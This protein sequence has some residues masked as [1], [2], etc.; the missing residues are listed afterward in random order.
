VLSGRVLE[1]D[2]DEDISEDTERSP[3]PKPN[4]PVP[5]RRPPPPAR[6]SLTNLND[7]K[8]PLVSASSSPSIQPP[9]SQAN[10]NNNNTNVQPALPNLQNPL[11]SSDSGG[12]VRGRGRG[13]GPPPG[14]AGLRGSMGERG[15]P[16]GGLSNS[17]SVPMVEHRN[18]PP[19]PSHS[20]SNHSA[21]VAPSTQGASS[22]SESSSEPS[23]PPSPIR[24]RGDIKPRGM[25]RPPP[26]LELTR[27][28]S[29]EAIVPSS[30]NSESP[31]SDGNVTP[32]TP[33]GKAKPPPPTRKLPVNTNA[34]INPPVS[35]KKDEQQKPPSSWTPHRKPPSIGLSLFF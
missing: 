35:P 32:P 12:M 17:G 25:R 7:Q 6:S 2:D 28:Q 23:N 3:S 1:N 13:V 11:S 16:Q 24:G 31:P 20:S 5:Q 34:A 10:N 33:E 8:P 26:P 4:P 15:S 27:T 22:N 21:N 19:P 9:P 29:S 30:P 14:R 18:M